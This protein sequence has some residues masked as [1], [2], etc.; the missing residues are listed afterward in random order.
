MARTILPNTLPV[1]IVQTTLVMGGAILF[2][3]GLAFLGLGD[4][5]QLSWGFYLGLNRQFFLLELVGCHHPRPDD[6]LHRPQPEPDR[7]WTP[8]CGKPKAAGPLVPMA[9]QGEPL[10]SVRNLT[11]AF[12]DFVAVDDLSFDLY[13]GQTLAIVGESG[14]G[15]SVTAL[16]I[17]R[18]VELGTRAKITRG[19]IIF[20]R[21]DGSS[22]DLVLAS[23][24]RY[25][26]H[27]G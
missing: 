17:M 13:P 5:S 8:G 25:A 12:D 3:A 27:E 15:K 11:V 4:P 19:E 20:N 24:A 18:L 9:T 21:P 2:E 10:L 1:I 23:G 14:S 7:R 16:S 22:L 26:F 6:L